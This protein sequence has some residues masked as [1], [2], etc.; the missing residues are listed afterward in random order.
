MVYK[1]KCKIKLRN[2]PFD[3]QNCSLKFGSWIYPVGELDIDFFE[4]KEYDLSDYQDG[5]QFQLLKI[6]FNRQIKSYR[7]RGNM[8]FVDIFFHFELERNS[9]FFEQVN[10]L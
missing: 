3:V 9:H 1:S 2:F 6:N 8:K 5:S 10:I 4:T 7:A